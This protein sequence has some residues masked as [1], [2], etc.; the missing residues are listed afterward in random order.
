MDS[1]IEEKVGSEAPIKFEV[2]YMM[3]YLFKRDGCV[4]CPAAEKIVEELEKEMKD[5]DVIIVDAERIDSALEYELAHQQIFVFST[6]TII[7][8]SDRR[9]RY[10]PFSF[11]VVPDIDELRF[12]IRRS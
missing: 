9:R 10:E 5:L 3:L 1:L 12:V 6:P 8:Y 4:N 2:I 11:G 7:L